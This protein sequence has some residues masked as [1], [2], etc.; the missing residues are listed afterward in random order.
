MRLSPRVSCEFV[1][2]SQ[3]FSGENERTV[4]IWW[5]RLEVEPRPSM[6][7]QEAHISHVEPVEMS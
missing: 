2:E 6:F 7:C 5:Q 3:I 4:G 1:N